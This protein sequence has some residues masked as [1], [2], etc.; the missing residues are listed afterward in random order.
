MSD[1]VRTLEPMIRRLGKTISSLDGDS[2]TEALLKIIH[3]PG[4]TTPVE[5][6]LVQSSLQQIT[7]QIE[8][9]NLAH[10]DLLKVAAQIGR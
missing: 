6:S 10:Q 3:Q 4:W 7:S 9:A 2:R 5:F 1:H 8:A